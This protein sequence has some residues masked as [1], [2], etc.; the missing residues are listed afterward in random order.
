MGKQDDDLSTADIVALIREHQDFQKK[1]EN[2]ERVAQK[3]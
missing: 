2:Q 3:S 1:N